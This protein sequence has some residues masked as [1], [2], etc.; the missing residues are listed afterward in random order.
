MSELTFRHLEEADVDDVCFWCRSGGGRA[1]RLFERAW[2]A[3]LR[4][5]EMVVVHRD[6][7]ALGVGVGVIGTEMVPK[8]SP[9]LGQV[10]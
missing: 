2:N 1:Q 8:G 5:L 6:I 10:M 4:G 3:I 9:S 7:A